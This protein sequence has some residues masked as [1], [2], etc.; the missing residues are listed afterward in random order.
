MHRLQAGSYR[1]TARWGQ[2]APPSSDRSCMSGVKPDPQLPLFV[3]QDGGLGSD[4]A[5]E[6]VDVAIGERAAEFPGG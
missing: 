4:G 2:R 1:S 3:A 6:L 5:D